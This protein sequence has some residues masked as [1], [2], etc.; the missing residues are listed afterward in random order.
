MTANEIFTHYSDILHKLIAGTPWF[1]NY[2]QAPYCSEY[3][4]LLNLPDVSFH[5]GATRACIVDDNYDWVIKFDVD[6]DSTESSSCEREY[7]IYQAACRENCDN[8]LCEVIDLGDFDYHFLAYPQCEVDRYVEWYDDNGPDEF[9]EDLNSH[10]EEIGEMDDCETHLH[11]YAYR[12]AIEGCATKVNLSQHERNSLESI[13][14][15]L[16][17]RNPR[18][19]EMFTTLYGMDEYVRFTDFVVAHH[20]NDL[21]TGNIG[22]VD[23]ALKLI[24]YAGYHSSCSR[25]FD[26]YEYEDEEEDYDEE[27]C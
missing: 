25:S 11:L 14:S 10:I 17:D 26:E 15:P 8:Y 4:G 3:D 2:V 20:I 24:D 7:R 12:R 19:A 16:K 9:E 18:I 27:N 21:H 5:C 22:M 1:A 6:F 13:S 23:G